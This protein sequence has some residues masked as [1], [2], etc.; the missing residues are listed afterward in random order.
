MYSKEVIAGFRGEYQF[1]SNFYP[2]RVT[3]YAMAFP[4]VEAAFQ[5]AKCADLAD[6]VRFLDLSPAEA[7]SWADM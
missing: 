4:S 5:A 7:K 2:C 3:F 6:R 1:L